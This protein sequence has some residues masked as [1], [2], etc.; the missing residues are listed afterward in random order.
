MERRLAAILFADVAGYTRLMDEYE[1]DTHNRLMALFE[2]VINPALSS[3]RGQIVKN[4]GDGFVARF[5][6]VSDA[7]ECAVAVQTGVFSREA[8]QP[9]ERR[10]AFRVGLHV[11]DIVVEAHDVYGAGVNLAARLQEIA[12]PGTLAISAS[13]REQLGSKLKLPTTDLGSLTLRN[14][15]GPV[16]VFRV[17]TSP[18]RAGNSLPAPAGGTTAAAVAHA[19]RT[20][21]PSI[22]VLPFRNLQPG[23]GDTYIADGLVEEIVHALAGLKELFVISRASTLGFTSSAPDAHAI[24]R[25]L[26]VRNILHGSVRR[27]GERLRIGAELSD[28]ETGEIIANNQYDGE[29][30]QLFELQTRVAIQV[31]RTIVPQ[32][33]ERELRRAMRNPPESRTAYDLVLEALRFLYRLDAEAH[34]RA[35]DLFQKAIC[36]DP[37]YALPYTY[38]A[39]WHIF[40]VGEGWSSDPSADAYEAARVAAA[41]IERDG[42][43]AVALAIFGH[44]QSF[45]VKDYDAAIDHFERALEAS[46]NCAIAWTMSSATYGYLGNG[47][48]AIE[49]AERGLRLSPLDAHVFWHEAILAQAY[50]VQGQYEQA[51]TWAKRAAGHNASAIFNIRTLAA[52]LLALGRQ[53]EAQQCAQRLMHIQPN[54]RLTEYASLCPFTKPIL[55]AWIERLRQ[56]GLPE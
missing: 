29:L 54:F 26:G 33:H 22:A 10:V 46:P 44:V 48:A 35:R 5:E 32:V 55:D 53:E 56:A 31:A 51:V 42:N 49:R 8:D 14:I 25:E 39:Y 17:V 36:L 40:R 27:Y 15:A 6:S 34:A 19:N 24:S 11:G 4:T 12:E 18:T 30:S 41:A 50:Y 20:A 37:D 13:V 3:S 21:L 38:L 7:F 43:D 45:L 16:R 47:V 23:P 1:A 28:A 9:R 2:E 52:S